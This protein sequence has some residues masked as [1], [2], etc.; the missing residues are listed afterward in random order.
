MDVAPVPG[1]RSSAVVVPTPAEPLTATQS[2]DAELLDRH[3]HGDPAAFAALLE[4]HGPMVRR[5][6]RRALADTNDVEDAF[7]ATFLA[8]LHKARS[9]RRR[10]SVASWLY[11]VA[12]RA[13]LAVRHVGRPNPA[14]SPADEPTASPALLDEITGRELLAGLDEEMSGI[15]EKYRAPLVLCYMEGVTS[16]EAARQLG[17][18]QRTLKRRLRRGREYLAQRL[19]RRGLALGLLLVPAALS[20]ASVPVASHQALTGYAQGQ[21]AVPPHLRKLMEHAI[22]P[23]PL[24]I[25]P[26]LLALL[27]AVGLAV[28]VAGL[29]GT[30][31]P[32]YTPAVPTAPAAAPAPKPL[33]PP[34]LTD[35]RYHDEPAPQPLLISACRP[36]LI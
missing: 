25:P 12:Y 27:A 4:R 29:R 16:D 24:P 26:A 17:W 30:P 22:P 33:P 8:L 35:E 11:K 7:Q 18:S 31:Q 9:I 23:R 6:C 32:S 21:A 19:A 20:A 2:S 15:A 10:P 36:M 13:A 1:W 5:V 28:A 34:V 3:L 14:Q